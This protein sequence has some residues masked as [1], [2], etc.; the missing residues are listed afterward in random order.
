MSCVAITGAG[1]GIGRLT[2]LALAERGHEVIATTETDEQ[3]RALSAEAPHLRVERV[4]ITT[5]DVARM[6]DWEIDVLIDNAGVGEAGPLVDIPLERIR[7]LFEVNVIGTLAVTQVVARG[8]IARR[9]GRIIIM[10]S[11]AGVLTAPAFGP[12]AMTKFSIEA[13][14]KTMRTELAPFGVDVTLVKPAPHA[15]GFMDALVASMWEWFNEESASAAGSV[16]YRLMGEFHTF[17]QLDPHRLVE[18]LVEL[19]EAET[20][21]ESN[22]VPESARDQFELG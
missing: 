6:A 8:M 19:C 13:M 22:Y 4:D 3:A 12:F 1:T 2:A 11:L 10:S 18:R 5:D 14:G 15:T 20:T 7:H 9:R 16:L 17:G 21:E